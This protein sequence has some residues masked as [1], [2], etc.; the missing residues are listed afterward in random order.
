LKKLLL[1]IGC[2]SFLI[3]TGLAEQAPSQRRIVVHTSNKLERVYFLIHGL[4]YADMTQNKK[5]EQIDSPIVKYLAR[6][7]RCADL[8]RSRLHT[9]AA[10]EALV[11]IPWNKKT[12]GPVHEFNALAD[13]LLGD[14]FFLLDCSDGLDPSFW[15]Q[16]EELFSKE[17]MSNLEGMLTKQ[18]ESW[19]KE[20]LLTVLHAMNCC[21]QFT[22]MLSARRLTLDPQH[23]QCTSWGASYEGCVTKYSLNIRHI[24]QLTNPIK[25]DFNMT[26]PDAYFL[27]DA[28]ERETHLIDRG[29]LLSIFQN[30]DQYIACYSGT[31]QSLADKPAYVELAIDST[32]ANIVSKQGIRL[33]PRTETYHLPNAPF[34]YYEPPQK[35][36]QATKNGLRVPAHSGYVYRLA[37]APAFIFANAGMTLDRFRDMLTR[38]SQN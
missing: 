37:K 14:R 18:K 2:L 9:L 38:I 26:V 1:T 13:S 21:R 31:S 23:V 24:L 34:G 27:L 10:N 32:N 6:E 3:S 29:L 22:D 35:L 28:A 8:W 15:Q 16:Q 33:W 36:V 30:G 7:R 4:C 19:N 20:E 11:V 17:I 12:T 5:Q 25:I